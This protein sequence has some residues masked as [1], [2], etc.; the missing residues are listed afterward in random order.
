MKE[1]LTRADP[2][3]TIINNIDDDVHT[4]VPCS[5]RC[6][7]FRNFVVPKTSFKCF[8]TKRIY[9][10][11]RSTSCISK[12]VIYIAFCLNCLKE[13]VRYIVDWKL[14]LRNYKSHVKKVRSC[15]IVNHFTDVSSDTD[16]PSKNIRFII[17]D[18]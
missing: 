14:R 4:Y 10:V 12:N 8:P 11:R 2:Y 1:S 17:V 16:D 15:S 5:K 18:Q 7:S 3:S 6:D 9:K 13:G